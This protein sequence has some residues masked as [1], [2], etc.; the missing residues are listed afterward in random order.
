MI[1]VVDDDE[2]YA[3]AL[4]RRLQ[5]H[6]LSA[7]YFTAPQQL[8]SNQQTYSHLLLDLNLGN[9]SILSYLQSIRQHHPDAKIW[10]VTGYASIATT[11]NAIKAGADDYL[12]KPLDFNALL[13]RLGEQQIDTAEL[14]PLSSAQLEWEHIQRVLQEN[15]GNISAAARVLNMH[16]RTLQRKLQKKPLW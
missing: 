8:L 3:S 1:A 7:C 10:V 14:S 11:V 4:V 16:R 12:T 13:A 9:D 5:R 6:N 2:V 15:N